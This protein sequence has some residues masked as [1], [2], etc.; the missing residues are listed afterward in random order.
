MKRKILL[1]PGP[2]TTSL[3]VKKALMSEDICHRVDEFIEVIEKLRKD[4]LKVVHANEEEYVAVPF[5]GSGTINMDVT[6]NS[7]LD[8]DTKVLILNNGAYSNRATKICEA[9]HLPHYELKLP[10]DKKIDL[11][12]VKKFLIK[13]NDISLVYTTHHETGSGLINNIRELGKIVQSYGAQFVID[14]TSSYALMPINIKED[15]IDF[16]FAS[17]QKG[18]H[19]MTGLSFVIGKRSLIEKSKDYPTRSYY[20]NLYHQ[21]YHFEYGAKQ[22]LFTPPVQLVY[23]AT[24]GLK[25][26]FLE[27]EMNKYKRIVKM[28]EFVIRKLKELGFK[29]YLKEEDRGPLVVSV[30]YPSDSKWDFKKIHE[31]LYERDFTLFPTP[32]GRVPTFRIGLLG[33]LKEEDLENFFVLFQKALEHYKI[34]IPVSYES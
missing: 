19:A 9:Y 34:K 23:A 31:Y 29:L 26:Y 10:F 18:I 8:K 17:A 1:N 7:L 21:Y 4:L 13:H 16:L 33:D 25:E 12:I 20:T 15:N 24:Q 11:E 22:M 28:N 3:S 2:V 6:L 27:G 32:V 30:L 14:A 5:T